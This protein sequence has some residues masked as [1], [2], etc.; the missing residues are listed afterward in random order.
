MKKQL[1]VSLLI[2]GVVASFMGA[3]TFA[4]F[5]DTETSAGN[6]FTAGILDLKVKTDGE[7]KD[8]PNVKAINFG[9]MVP[10]ESHTE[11]F[12]LKNAGNVDGKL[13]LKIKNPV[14]NENGRE[15]P[16]IDAGDPAGAEFDPTGYDA[17]GGNGELWDQCKMKIFVDADQSGDMQWNEPVVY[18][19]PMGL[20]MTSYYSIPLDTNLFPA[21]QGYDE[22][23]NSNEVIWIGITVT[24]M[25]DT[26]SPFTSQPQYNGLTNNMAMGDDI[27]FDIEF[28]LNQI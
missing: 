9:P 20:D 1:L 16:E 23:M 17:N 28:G 13:T 21:N 18:S 24:F 19:G 10:G 22:T 15:E 2:V 11:L 25:D 7:W 27:E 8:D 4:V 6:T 14:S 26:G 3:G 5:S 12:K